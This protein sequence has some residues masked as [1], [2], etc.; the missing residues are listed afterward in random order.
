MEPSLAGKRNVR[1]RIK[2]ANESALLS[3]IFFLCG[4]LYSYDQHMYS[5]D[6]T[7]VMMY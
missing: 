5:R 4:T 3:C 1:R 2:I 7:K 6:I